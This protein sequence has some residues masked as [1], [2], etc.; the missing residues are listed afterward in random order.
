MQSPDPESSTQAARQAEED[1]VAK[2]AAE[3]ADNLEAQERADAA[4]EPQVRQKQQRRPMML[5]E[6]QLSCQQS[7]KG[8]SG[9][10]AVAEATKK[11]KD[12]AL[13]LKLRR[14]LTRKFTALPFSARM[15]HFRKT[16]ACATVGIIE[17]IRRGD[18]LS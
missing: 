1:R 17:A 14:K 10:D 7:W 11:A 9:R 3:N 16:A 8:A 15:S 5:L 12:R 6:K 18:R 4:A 13:P 2:E